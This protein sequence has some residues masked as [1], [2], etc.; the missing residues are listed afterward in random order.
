MNIL[1][2]PIPKEPSKMND[3]LLGLFNSLFF[4]CEFI[5]MYIKKMFH[6]DGIRAYLINKLYE[7]P[8]NE[9][10]FYIPNLCYLALNNSCKSLERFLNDKCI[11]NF[12][13]YL[14]A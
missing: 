3:S 12:P 11:D 10:E 2:K 13:L 9:L 8:Q 14:K 1:L 6:D 4:N 7:I 5:I